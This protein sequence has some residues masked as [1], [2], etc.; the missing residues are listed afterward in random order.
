MSGNPSEDL[1]A[2]MPPPVEWELHVFWEGWWDKL[3]A[4]PTDADFRLDR[5]PMR[6]ANAER[7][8]LRIN[9][10][11]VV[12][13]IPA[14]AHEYVVNGRT[15][16]E[17]MLYQYRWRRDRRSGIVND[18]NAA[19][20]DPWDLI[21]AIHRAVHVSVETMRIVRALPP[22]FPEGEPPPTVSL[23]SD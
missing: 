18:P 7:S 1:D 20:P 2:R 14:E 13:G 16:L 15:P 8:V 23:D 12:T 3:G 6:W 11:V 9:D 19:F 4:G 5:R 22:L 21:V 10:Q 17:W